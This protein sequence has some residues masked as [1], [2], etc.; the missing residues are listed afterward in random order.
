MRFFFRSRQFKIIVSV[1]AAVIVLAI[2]FG[3]SGSRMTPGADVLSAITAPIRD[4]ATSIGGEIKGFFKSMSDN[5][6]VMLENEELKKQI[7]ELTGKLSDYEDI[8]AQNSFYKEYLGIKES[9]PD[10]QF[11]DA[12]VI[13]RDSDD[14]FAG[15]TVNKGSLSG[16]HKHDPVIT[17]AGLVGYVSEV[18]LS[19]C[20]ITTILCP[21]IKLGALDSRT[22]DS[23]VVT[24]DLDSAKENKCK[25]T[26]LSRSCSVSIGDFIQTSGEGIFPEGILVGKIESIGSD[27][28]NT[29]IYAQLNPFVD[30]SSLKSVM[31]ITD[32]EGKGGITV[33]SGEKNAE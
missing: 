8:S 10:F 15:F 21:D 12:K 19:S 6:Q 24:G 22:N 31:I 5:N 25:I 14:P 13:S 7:N 9:N 4:F 18:G 30:F 28:Y 17:E 16:I 32:F 29:S 33:G 20:K 26:N 23:G 27:K 2:I 11:A 1:F 3:I